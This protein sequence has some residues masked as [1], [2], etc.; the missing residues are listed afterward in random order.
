MAQRRETYSGFLIWMPIWVIYLQEFRS[1]IRPIATGSINRRIPSDR[2]ATVLSI[3]QLSAGLVL[4]IMVPQAGAL[5]DAVGFQESFGLLLIVMVGA[6]GLFAFLWRR[7]HIGE[8][9]RLAV[10]LNSMAKPQAGTAHTA[11][12]MRSDPQPQTGSNE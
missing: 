6:G 4:A 9:M 2:R 8:Q 5:A 12:S 10:R 11:T 7:L 1:M 3:F